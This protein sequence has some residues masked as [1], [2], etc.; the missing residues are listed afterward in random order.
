MSE[1]IQHFG[2]DWRLLLAQAVNF[3]ILLW[4][5]KKFVYRPVLASLR[6]RRRRIEEGLEFTQAAE[7]RLKRIGKEREAKLRKAHIDALAIISAAEDSAKKKEDEIVLEA[8]RKAD[9]AVADAKRLIDEEKAKMGEE[10]ARGAEDLVRLG[11]ARVL[12]KMPPAGRDK[13]LIQGALQ[14]LK[15]LRLPLRGSKA[16][17][18]IS[19]TASF[20]S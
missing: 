12:G 15:A 14:E 11:I 13:Q 4:V 10:V 7:E 16:A 9:Q 19:E 17:E 3:L 5:L 20:R 2:I 8:N 18:A 1:L 6:N